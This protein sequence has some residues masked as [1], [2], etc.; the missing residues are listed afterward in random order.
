[1]VQKEC[2]GLLEDTHVLVIYPIV[3][4]QKVE[5]YRVETLEMGNILLTHWYQ[6]K[7]SNTIIP[8][9]TI[10]FIVQD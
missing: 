1:M 9:N 6:W 2:F 10:I 5:V 7:I 8:V 4:Y 3:S